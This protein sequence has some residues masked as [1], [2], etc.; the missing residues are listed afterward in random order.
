M[1]SDSGTTN[2]H[3]SDKL[4]A[5]Q[6]DYTTISQNHPF[7]TNSMGENAFLLGLEHSV[8][9]KCPLLRGRCCGIVCY[10]AAGDTSIPCVWDRVLP[11]LHI[12]LG[13][14]MITQELG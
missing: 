11:S 8:S 2:M 5:K 1:A 7:V 6:T 3:L 10:T 14:G 4:D 9:I 12:H 13:G